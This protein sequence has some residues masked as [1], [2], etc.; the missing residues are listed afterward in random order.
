M[1]NKFLLKD[2]TEVIAGYT[3]RTA[4]ESKEDSSL[5]VLQAKNIL[6]DSTVDEAC[7]DKIVF[8][9]YRSRAIVKKGDVVISSKGNFRAGVISLGIKD[10]I[11]SSSVFIIHPKHAGI[12][13]EYLAIFLNSAAGQKQIREKVTGAVIDTILRRDLEEIKIFLPG[14]ERQKK[15]VEL[16][17]TNQRLQKALEGKKNLINSIN[18]ISINKLLKN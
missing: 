4:L 17:F 13:P 14:I 11:A 10:I 15:I 7:L 8:E 12:I 18:E 3:F 9:N 16:Y 6:N 1:N 5:F 2:I